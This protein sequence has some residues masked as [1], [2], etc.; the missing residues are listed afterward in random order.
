M[1]FC[2]TVDDARHL[3]QKVRVQLASG[4]HNEE[5]DIVPCDL[6]RA[7]VPGN[8]STSSIEQVESDQESRASQMHAFH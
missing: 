3:A 4:K 5:I 7:E 2:D 6:H 1:G 8:E